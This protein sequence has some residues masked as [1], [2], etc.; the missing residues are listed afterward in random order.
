MNAS[1]S[2]QKEVVKRSI[3]FAGAAIAVLAALVVIGIGLLGSVRLSRYVAQAQAAVTI[4]MVHPSAET[5]ARAQDSARRD[6]WPTFA[7]D[8]RR[9]GLETADTGITKDNV[10]HLALR[11]V[12]ELHEPTVASP[13]VAGGRVYVA[14]SN[15]SVIAFAASDGKQLWRVKVGNTIH[16]TPA[17][18]G[19]S[20]LVG[21]YGMFGKIGHVPYGAS[22]VS[23]DAA[24]G[25]TRW[26]TALPGLVR[27]E[28]VILGSTIYEGLAGGDEF[29]GC[30]DGRI[31][32]LDLAT[33]RKLRPEW[34]AVG[35]RNGGGIWSPLSTDGTKVVVG[36]GNSCK[37]LGRDRF[38]DAIVAI[39]P[40]TMHV[41]WKVSAFYPGVDDSDVGGGFMML[42]GRGYVVGKSG[43]LY[44]ID[45]HTG[46]LID[47]FDLKPFARN[48]G[49]IG[50]PTSDGNTIVVSSGELNS[51]WDDKRSV[52]TAEA[53]LVGLDADLKEHYRIHSGY[54]VHGYA[55]FVPGIGFAALDRSLLAFDSTN[56]AILW[57]GPLDATAYAS[58]TIVPSGLYEV[59]NSGTVFAYGLP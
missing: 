36:T 4:A 43:Y 51:P 29:S 59:T 44:Q 1:A 33:G 7:H 26:R 46:K 49:S 53:D 8:Q 41:S 10:S 16:M 13:I 45:Q 15:G 17:L 12:H 56:G 11:W 31:V 58:P 3:W 32:V 37:D 9:S 25:A 52:E 18:E 5:I 39:D 2:I 38:G 27:S 48:G 55:A 23:L 24:T 6:D 30:F 47:R 19:S 28:P 34:Y 42:N 50:T 22:F 21:V 35:G 14:T 57:R 54:A 40:A 20:L